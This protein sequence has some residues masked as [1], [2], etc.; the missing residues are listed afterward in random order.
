MNST[1]RARRL[2]TAEMMSGVLRAIWDGDGQ[3]SAVIRVGVD[4]Y[5][6]HT[7]SIVKV[8]ILLNLALLLPRGWLVD[9]HLHH[10]IR[11]GHHN[12]LKRGEVGADVFVVDRPET[13]EPKASFVEVAGFFHLTPVLVTHAVINGCEVDGG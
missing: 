12:R 3:P 4:T 8:N 9:R 7:S 10:I 13:V 1:P 11:T 6:L 5:M 2:D